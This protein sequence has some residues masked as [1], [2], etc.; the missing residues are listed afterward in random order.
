[1]EQRAMGCV[2]SPYDSRDYKLVCKGNTQ[3]FPKKYELT[4]RRVKD[5]GSTGSCV[6]HSL[7]SIIEYYNYNQNNDDTCMSVG[8]I[9]GNRRDSQYKD[10]GMIMRD[11]L[12]AIRKYGDV[13]DAMFPYNAEVP[14]A[15]KLFEN[16]VDGLYR[17]GYPHHITQYCRVNDEASIKTSLL[18]SCPV[19][20]AIEWFDDMEPDE[21][22]ILVS[23]FKRSAG[24]HCMFVY[25]WNETGW[26]VQNSWGTG[27]GNEGRF[28]LP[29]EFPLEEAWIVI[30]DEVEG[31]V[32]KTPYKSKIGKFF[33][34]IINKIHRLFNK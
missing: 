28:I 20:I 1:M 29:Y 13:P 12:A 4:P 23:E 30:D 8:Y 19:A 9:Y 3:V 6:A 18:A 27:W 34:K 31:L 25:G 2:F 15:I 14:R 33:A 16:S 17:V 10:E 21:N 32:I 7:S 26:L 11:A 24:G 22:G 5:Q